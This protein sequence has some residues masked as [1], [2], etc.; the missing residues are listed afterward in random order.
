MSVRCAAAS[1]AE[2]MPTR[3]LRS[4]TPVSCASQWRLEKHSAALT[5]PA[6]QPTWCQAPHESCQLLR[7][8]GFLLLA[9]CLSRR[10]CAWLVLVHR[11]ASSLR[12]MLP[13]ALQL[14][15]G[16]A[17]S[18][19][20]FLLSAALLAAVRCCKCGERLHF[21]VTVSWRFEGVEATTT[22]STF[23][24]QGVESWCRWPPGLSCIA[25]HV[26][27][28]RSKQVG[29]LFCQAAGSCTGV[30]GSDEAEKL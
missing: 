10:A 28:S 2:H 27:R 7:V 15:V 5:R 18:G 12:L 14:V 4:D 19:S 23:M 1:C 21:N 8:L 16:I 11:I 20:C 17:L 13:C 22:V 3:P 26:A 30:L 6:V 25:I 29:L 24:L 9:A